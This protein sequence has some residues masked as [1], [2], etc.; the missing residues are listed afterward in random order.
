MK[1]LIGID[2]ATLVEAAANSECESA[3]S[4]TG[5]I[6]GIASKLKTASKAAPATEEFL[7]SKM[8][9]ATSKSKAAKK[10]PP[11]AS[12][13]PKEQLTFSL[14]KPS[15][16]KFS[17]VHPSEEYSMVGVPVLEDPDNNGKWYFVMPDVEENLPEFVAEG[18]KLID[19]YAAIDHTGSMFVW[20]VK[21]SDTDW[22][23]A[24]TKA[25]KKARKK[26]VAVRAQMGA[27]TY[28]AQTPVSPLAEPDW[29]SFPSW[30]EMLESA[31]AGRLVLGPSD[32]I[33]RKLAGE[34]V[35]DEEDDE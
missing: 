30:N 35:S 31:L 4:V 12:K 1:T 15:A 18:M 6:A 14:M 13:G 9:A 3:P 27:N 5:E 10:N 32:A 21:Q 26:W 19:I 11:A 34:N 2:A 20:Y 33:V 8:K 17:R 22:Y 7:L 23:P 16:K 28:I 24:A 25:V 29:T